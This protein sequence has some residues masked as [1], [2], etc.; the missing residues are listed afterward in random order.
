M[1]GWQ[2]DTVSVWAS[3]WRAD[4][5]AI[6]ATFVET[7]LVQPDGQRLEMAT[8]WKAFHGAHWVSTEGSGRAAIRHP[9]LHS[10]LHA[11]G[12][13]VLHFVQLECH[14]NMRPRKGA[15]QL[16]Q[17][18]S[19]GEFDTSTSRQ[20]CPHRCHSGH[21]PSTFTKKPIQFAEVVQTELLRP[22]CLCKSHRL[23]C[24]CHLTL[25]V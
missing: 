21:Q 12:L 10:A 9:S 20:K 25:R 16:C 11:R 7:V 13:A 19:S 17:R 24:G 8:I 23:Q 15:C 18:S 5:E 4:L 14:V 6:D 1:L 2:S 22:S 3:Y